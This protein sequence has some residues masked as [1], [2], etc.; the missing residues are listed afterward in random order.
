MTDKDFLNFAWHSLTSGQ[1]D[2]ITVK[3]YISKNN[4]KT[5]DELKEEIKKL[6]LNDKFIRSGTRI[7][8]MK[9]YEIPIIM[10]KINYESNLT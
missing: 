7:R 4:H 2:I 9:K 1:Q 10:K 8:I 3:Y 5:I 6:K